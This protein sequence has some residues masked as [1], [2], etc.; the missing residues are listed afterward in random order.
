MLS[1][2][3]WDNIAQV[4]YWCNVGPGHIVIFSQK[5][6]LY[7]VVST[8][9]EQHCIGILSS[10]CCPNTSET[11]LHKKI[12]CEQCWLKAHRYTF[13]EKP[14]VSYM[15]G[16]LF[17]TGYYIT[18]QSWLFSFNVGSGVHLR[19]TGQQWTRVNFDLNN[20]TRVIK[21][22][23][24]SGICR[25]RNTIMAPKWLTDGMS[26]NLPRHEPKWKSANYRLES[27]SDE[28]GVIIKRSGRKCK[29]DQY[30]FWN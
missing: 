7:N 5:N 18:E 25:V 27:H 29:E 8:M 22:W 11:T 28:V 4:S 6:N 24:D 23:K 12:T 20:A 14:A 30:W 10:Q 9:L 13:A 16:S 19:L 3:I 21:K 15:S 1:E 2:Y 26:A 17:L